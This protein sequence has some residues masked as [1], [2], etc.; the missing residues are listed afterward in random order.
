[1]SFFPN[2]ALRREENLPNVYRRNIARRQYTNARTTTAQTDWRV[3]GCP[4]TSG[5]PSRAQANMQKQTMMIFATVSDNRGPRSP[6]IF[7]LLL[8]T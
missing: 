3:S 5:S 6:G 2:G 4:K 8:P 7:I 1:M